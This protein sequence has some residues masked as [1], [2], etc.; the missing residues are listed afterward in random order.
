MTGSSFSQNVHSSSDQGS[1]ESKSETGFFFF[2]NFYCFV[3]N[4]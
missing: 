1:N 3:V 2:L 4:S